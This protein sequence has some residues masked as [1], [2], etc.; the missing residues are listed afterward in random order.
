MNVLRQIEVIEG[1]RS[2]NQDSSD[3]NRTHSLNEEALR[4]YSILHNINFVCRPSLNVG[5]CVICVTSLRSSP[6][7]ILH[8]GVH[9]YGTDCVR[10]FALSAL[11]L[12]KY[13]VGKV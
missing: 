1:Q 2:R 7:L 10:L 5:Q 6:V 11:C 8:A 9:S 12:S 3:R 4:R 13:L